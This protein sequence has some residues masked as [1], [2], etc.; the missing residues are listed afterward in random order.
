MAGLVAPAARAVLDHLFTDPA[1]TPPATYYVGLST[2]TPTVDGANFTEPSAGSYVR[3][4]TTA[5]DWSPAS[6]SSPSQK[7]NTAGFVWPMATADWAAGADLVAFGLFDADT[8]G[9]LVITGPLA[10]PKSVMAG[11]TPVCN[12]GR[13]VIKLGDPADP[14]AAQ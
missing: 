5:A 1:Y 9:A 7:T 4:A 13:L 2:T 10:V 14:Y 3:I 12:P 8:A 6:D 11:D